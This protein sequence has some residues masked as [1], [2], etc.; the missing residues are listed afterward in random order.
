MVWISKQNHTFRV[1]HGAEALAVHLLD[2]EQRALAELFGATTGDD[3][4]KFARCAWHDG[5]DRATILDDC[6]RW[7]VGR[8]I[9]Q[10]DGGDHVGF[11]VEPT[12]AHA[13]PWTTQLGFQMVRDL[14]PGHPA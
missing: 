3:K 12:S 9:D 11:I 2:A 7:L 5:P 8:V 13:D 14:A 10:V 6:R 4:D 1:A